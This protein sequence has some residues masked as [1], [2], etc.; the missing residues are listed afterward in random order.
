MMDSEC[1]ADSV[2]P[3]LQYNAHLDVYSQEPRFTE[4]GLGVLRAAET[5]RNPAPRRMPCVQPYRVYIYHVPSYGEYGVGGFVVEGEGGAFNTCKSSISRDWPRHP[6]CLALP[7]L[8]VIPHCVLLNA[9][10]SVCTES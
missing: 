4:T 8:I 7:Q 10:W 1:S 9:Y 6:G 5:L 2:S 3:S